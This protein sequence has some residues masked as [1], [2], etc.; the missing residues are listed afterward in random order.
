MVLMM[1]LITQYAV[2]PFCLYKPLIFSFSLL[3]LY[4]LYICCHFFKMS[5]FADE[6]L[7]P[8][9]VIRRRRE[10]N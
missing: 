2:L 1:V 10:G 7:E 3:Y 8:V 6:F 9:V 5:M 4:Y